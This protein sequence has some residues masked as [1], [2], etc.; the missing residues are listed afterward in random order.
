LF[1]TDAYTPAMEAVLA[2]HNYD[3]ARLV[4]EKAKIDQFVTA[5]N[6]QEACKGATQNAKDEQ[7]SVVKALDKWMGAFTKIARVA[8]VDKKQLLEKLGIMVRSVKTKAQRGAAAKAAETRRK[9][10]LL[11]LAA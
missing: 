11:K 7:K 8:F 9:Q 3:E 2:E 5:N 6:A 10:K 4:I 1:N